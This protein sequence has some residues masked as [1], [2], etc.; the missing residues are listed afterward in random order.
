M[1][2]ISHCELIHICG[3]VSS[4]LKIQINCKD[5]LE[6]FRCAEVSSHA[7]KNQYS[8]EI[9]IGGLS[10]PANLYLQLG[11]LAYLVMA[12]LICEKCETA[13]VACSN[14]QKLIIHFFQQS[15]FLLDIPNKECGICGSSYEQYYSVIFILSNRLLNNY[16]KYQNNCVQSISKPDEK[17]TVIT[18]KKENR[19]FSTLKK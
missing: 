17:F 9:S 3:Y 12:K 18:S 8:V 1:N 15:L 6:V 2:S 7:S 14:Q 13:F 5:C 16:S 10:V 4:Q 11:K 19:K